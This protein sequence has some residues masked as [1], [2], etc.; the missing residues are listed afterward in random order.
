MTLESFLESRPT[1]AETLHDPRVEIWEGAAPFDQAENR[2]LWESLWERSRSTIAIITPEAIARWCRRFGD[3]ESLRTVVVKD[4]LPGGEP[5]L[6]AAL[7][8]IAANHLPM[9][10]VGDLPSNSWFQ[11]GDLLL[12]ESPLAMPPIE[13]VSPM[14]IV[15]D[16]LIEGLRE[17]PW[18]ILWIPTVRI[19]AMRWR[20][21]IWALQQAGI[22]VDVK[23]RYLSGRVRLAGDWSTYQSKLSRKMRSQMKRKEKK[24]A[25]Q[26]EVDFRYNERHTKD[27]V[28]R[29]MDLIFQVEDH[30]W[31]GRGGSSILQVDGIADLYR[32]VAHELAAKDRLRTITLHVGGRP[33]AGGLGYAVKNVLT[34][35]KIG[36][37]EEFADFKPGMIMIHRLIEACH[38][39]PSCET[40]DFSSPIQEYHRR[41]RPTMYRVAR[42]GVPLCRRGAVMLDGIRRCRSVIG[43]GDKLSR[44]G[45]LGNGE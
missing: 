45:D 18:P 30:G 17:L 7:P 31:K 22:A 11:C 4:H 23:D 40:V 42:L 38:A 41:W 16:R 34:L 1:D 43:R 29:V 8:L 13:G 14:K 32:A 44:A 26:G 6:L 3:C 28:D 19:E 12:D 9:T 15:L 24:L 21:L 37:E 5:R 20:L 10:T 39:D 27:E 36:Y 35:H 33:V 25:Q 2:A